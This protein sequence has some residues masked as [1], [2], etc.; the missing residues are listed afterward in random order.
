MKILVFDDSELHRKSA[1]ALLKGHD[2][3]IVSTYD[4]AQAVLDPE[5]DEDLAKRLLVE[6]GWPEGFNAYSQEVSKERRESYLNQRTEFHKKATPVPDFDVVLTDLMVP[7]SK[8]AMGGAGMRLAGQEM[9]LGTTIA[10]LAL[11]KG[12]KLVAVITDMSHHAHPASAALDCFT[13]EGTFSVG[14]AKVLL[15]N[16]NVIT[17]VDAETFEELSDKFLNS[18]EGKKKYPY[19]ETTGGKDGVVWAKAWHQT[20]EKLM[21]GPE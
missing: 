17:R 16:G 8:Q 18:E 1:A 6:A 20:L 13:W 7:A 4:E 15:D 11:S 14:D 5:I 3:T 2:L 9:G 10:F 21:A 12:V 19:N